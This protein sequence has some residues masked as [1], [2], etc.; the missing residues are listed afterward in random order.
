MI[1][2]ASFGEL[3]EQS[4]AITAYNYL[5]EWLLLVAFAQSAVGSSTG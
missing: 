4:D 5:L 1:K 2:A 3:Y